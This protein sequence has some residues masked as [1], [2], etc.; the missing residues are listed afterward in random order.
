MSDATEPSRLDINWI[1]S[2]GSALGAVTAAVVLSTLGAAGT[3][4][5]AALGSLFITIGG[6]V[7]SHSLQLTKERVV[8]AHP[9][10][11]RRSA[12]A[13]KT[14][15]AV[16][17]QDA[18]PGDDSSDVDTTPPDRS[19]REVLRDLPWKRIAVTAGA[20]FVGAI[21]IIVA[22]ELWVGRPVSSFTGGTSGTSSGTSIPGTVHNTGDSGGSG[23]DGKE[24]TQSPDADPTPTQ[25]QD[26]EPGSDQ[27]QAPPDEQ[28]PPPAEPSPAAPEPQQPPAPQQGPAQ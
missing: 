27:D 11:G 7:Y 9:L 14:D 26:A 21:A 17:S 6:A 2:L 28:V 3:L 1:R 13:P 12:S 18:R 5:G 23:T 8:D 25:E 4:I 22:F 10:V 24:S 16:E 20:I 15:A 19:R